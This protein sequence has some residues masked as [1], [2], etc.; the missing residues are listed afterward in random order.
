MNKRAALILESTESPWTTEELRALGT[1]RHSAY[2]KALSKALTLYRNQDRAI[3]MSPE[4]DFARTQ[5]VRGRLAFLEDLVLLLEQDAS[6]KYESERK[7]AAPSDSE[8]GE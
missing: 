1:L 4:T 6:A 7:R 5:F 3:L 8:P 2:G